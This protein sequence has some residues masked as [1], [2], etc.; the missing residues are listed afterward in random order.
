M[1]RFEPLANVTSRPLA[2]CDM[3]FARKPSTKI[4]VPGCSEFL[5]KPRLNRLFGGPPSIIQRSAV[6]SGFFTSM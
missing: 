2:L 1:Q 4:S 6:P 3:S 5:V